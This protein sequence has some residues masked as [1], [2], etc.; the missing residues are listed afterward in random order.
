M[1]DERHEKRKA[2]ETAGASY[3]AYYER[4]YPVRVLGSRPAEPVTPEVLVEI[5]RLKAVR[6][7]AQAD[8]EA[9]KRS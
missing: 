5:E 7:T 3:R 2:Y 6:E 4:H 1:N 8:W 9:A